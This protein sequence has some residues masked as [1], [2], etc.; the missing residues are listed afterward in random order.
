MPFG[1][2]TF[3]DELKPRLNKTP[4]FFSDKTFPII[5]YFSSC[6]YHQRAE[7]S[8]CQVTACKFLGMR[9]GLVK[10]CPLSNS[11][12]S[13]FFLIW[14]FILLSNCLGGSVGKK[15]TDI[16]MPT[17][18]LKE[19]AVTS[20]FYISYESSQKYSKIIFIS[21]KYFRYPFRVFFNF[22]TNLRQGRFQCIP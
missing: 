10:P 21:Q 3:P 11:L 9:I 19:D 8:K 15:W 20:I 2:K 14:P 1:E 16:Q 6:G 17:L 18:I 5:S 13:K 4:I 12:L 22:S 7:M